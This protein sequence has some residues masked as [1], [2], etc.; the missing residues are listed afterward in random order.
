M[1]FIGDIAL[2]GINAINYE[3][4]EF[5]L[6]KPV[7]ANLEGALVSNPRKY[8]KK[9]RVVNDLMAISKIHNEITKVVEKFLTKNK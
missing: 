9:N 6:N 4:P 5:F 8:I 3:F 2:P 1:I 7:I